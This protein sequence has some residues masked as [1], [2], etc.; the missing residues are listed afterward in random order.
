M[1]DAMAVRFHSQPPAVG[2]KRACWIRKTK[3]GLVPLRWGYLE[4]CHG[5]AVHEI[6]VR[7]A[8]VHAEAGRS[9]INYSTL[10]MKRVRYAHKVT[11]LTVV[12]RE[13]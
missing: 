8:N 11:K 13:A 6:H 4:T 12:I 10:I 9:P 3:S 1:L 5:I 2:M 7:D